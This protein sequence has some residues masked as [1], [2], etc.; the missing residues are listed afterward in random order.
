MRLCNCG[1]A[2]LNLLVW[3]HINSLFVFW[4]RLSHYWLLCFWT[5][6]NKPLIVVFGYFW[7]VK[8]KWV[9]ILLIIY[10]SFRFVKAEKRD[11][12][13]ICTN[14]LSYVGIEVP[15]VFRFLTLIWYI[16]YLLFTFIPIYIITVTILRHITNHNFLYLVLNYLFL[17]NFVLGNL[18][19]I[20]ELKIHLKVM[21]WENVVLGISW[22]NRQNILK[23]ISF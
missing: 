1:C 20:I 8:L 22:L 9:L 18:R 3:E 4:Y 21:F 7:T 6:W 23:R 13:S 12:L 5:R 17:P 2:C 19:L 15:F 14:L 16:I 11:T 10:R